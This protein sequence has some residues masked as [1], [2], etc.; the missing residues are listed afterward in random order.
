MQSIAATDNRIESLQAL[1]TWAFIG[2]F[3]EHAAAPIK[4]AGLGV[5]V[6]FILSGFLLMYG[7]MERDLDCSLRS[8]LRFMLGKIKKLYPLH[9]I[10]MLAVAV[11]VIVQAL[12]GLQVGTAREFFRNMFLNVSLLQ[13]WYPDSSVGMSFNGV[14]WF[15]SVM[16]LL[17]FIF[18]WICKWIKSIKNR[19]F[20]VIIPVAAVLLQM[21]IL[22]LMFDKMG[23]IDFYMWFM[24]VFPPMRIVEFITGVCLGRAFKERKE[25]RPGTAFWTVIECAALAFTILIMALIHPELSANPFIQA[26]ETAGSRFIIAGVFWIYLFAVKKGLITRFLSNRIFVFIGN[27]S[28]DMFLIHTVIILW[29]KFV[30]EFLGKY[31]SGLKFWAV[32]AFEFALAIIL[33]LGYSHVRKHA[34]KFPA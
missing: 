13:A 9:I 18:P 15:L 27:L 30:L 12:I 24:Y 16:V 6:F 5:S 22:G 1:R 17:Y 14:A 26:F 10:T 23:A 28:S 29:I 7:Y 11:L 19:I 33:S 34:K 20:L 25:E 4:W 32:A 3:F 31:P 21:L 2:I 8:N